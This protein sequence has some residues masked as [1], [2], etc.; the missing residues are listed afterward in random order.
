MEIW[1]ELCSFYYT[2]MAFGL[3]NALIMFFKIVVVVF[4]DFIRKFLEVYLYDW[5]MF[6]LLK[7]N[8]E[9]LR[10]MLDRIRPLHISLNLK[11]A[12]FVHRLE[13]CWDMWYARI[14]D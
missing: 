5:K 3:K 10:L 8:I 13:L 4:K 1:I 14:V 7:E 2:A 12:S 9:S 11:N 6:S